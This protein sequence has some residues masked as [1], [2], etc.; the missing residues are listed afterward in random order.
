[1]S[2]RPDTINPDDTPTP[3]PNR[4][5]VLLM[6]ALTLYAL[7]GVVR[8]L[9]LPPALAVFPDEVRIFD[10]ISGVGWT[11][12]FIIMTVR[13]LRPTLLRPLPKP[14]SR[15]RSRSFA[16]T[17]QVAVLLTVFGLYQIVR[18]ALFAQADYDRQRLPFL[19]AIWLIWVAGLILWSV[20]RRIGGTGSQQADATSSLMK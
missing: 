19:I 12:V 14:V 13:L 1:M 5:L 15:R 9:T 20:F 18:L 10:V 2:P 8:M 17:G 11:V 16:T 4:R 7:V 3:P 6:I